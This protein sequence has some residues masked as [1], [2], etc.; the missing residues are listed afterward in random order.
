MASPVPWAE[1]PLMS[2][3]AH[4][5]ASLLGFLIHYKIPV[6]VYKLS[7]LLPS[8]SAWKCSPH[9]TSL[10]SISSVSL[11]QNVSFSSALFPQ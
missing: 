4:V 3:D 9:Q 2:L 8:P 10:R 5:D 11:G 6:C 1:Q 7:V